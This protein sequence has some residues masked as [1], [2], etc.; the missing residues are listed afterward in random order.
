LISAVGQA[1]LR[2]WFLHRAVS[3]QFRGAIAATAVAL[4]GAVV[5]V[6]SLSY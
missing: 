2:F 1:H 3:E 5:A 4:D 6:C